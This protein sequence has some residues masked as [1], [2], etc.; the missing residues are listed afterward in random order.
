M[1]IYQPI[2]KKVCVSS[3]KCGQTGDNCCCTHD[4]TLIHKISVI[5][6]FN[7]CPQNGKSNVNHKK[8]DDK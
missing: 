3:L 8:H 7:F 4:P 5:C 2:Q 6:A 1:L